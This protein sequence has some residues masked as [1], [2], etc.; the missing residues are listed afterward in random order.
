MSTNYPTSP[1]ADDDRYRRVVVL[2][3][4]SVQPAT[5]VEAEIERE[6]VA[7]DSFA[8]RDAVGQALRGLAAA[9]VIHRNGR[10]VALTRAATVTAGL[11]EAW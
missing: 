8:E 11:L 6:I 2:L 1:R 9:G 3:L 7:D 5:L 4:L 10:F